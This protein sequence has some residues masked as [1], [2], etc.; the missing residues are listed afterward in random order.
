MINEQMMD[1]MTVIFKKRKWILSKMY[2]LFH[3]TQLNHNSY[4]T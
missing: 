1:A 2:T 3:S 4:N